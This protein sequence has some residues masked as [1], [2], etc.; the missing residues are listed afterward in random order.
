MRYKSRICYLLEFFHA[1][2]VLLALMTIPIGIQT[3]TSSLLLLG[4]TVFILAAIILLFFAERHCRSIFSFLLIC[5]P[6]LFIPYFIRTNGIDFVYQLAAIILL[7]ITYFICRLGTSTPW[8]QEPNIYYEG[9]FLVIY[10]LGVYLKN[11]FIQNCM[12]YYAMGYLLLMLLYTNIT[13]MGNFLKL[14]RDVTNLPTQQIKLVNR[15]ILLILSIIT[16]AAMVLLPVSGLGTIITG[17]GNFLFQ[18][19]KGFIRLFHSQG[20]GD[21]PT[22]TPIE[23]P[24]HSSLEAFDETASDG[25]KWFLDL[26]ATIALWVFTFALLAVVIYGI[27]YV[28]RHFYRPNTDADEKL[29]LKKSF[30]EETYTSLK[31]NTKTKNRKIG[32][33]PQW[34]RSKNLQKDNSKTCW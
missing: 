18:L 1:Y 10:F 9:V 11:T 4:K 31:K 7:I 8:V 12:I 15:I 13:N 25:V 16:I 21:I 34:N 22:S 3:Y 33:R 20:D 19:I 24:K 6:L 27:Y 5:L 17:I 2:L 32:Q 30:M 14:N 23:P 26:L 28:I 29:F